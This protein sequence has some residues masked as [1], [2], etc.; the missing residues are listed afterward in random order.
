MGKRIRKL[1][2]NPI[3]ESTTEISDA[4]AEAHPSK[5]EGNPTEDQVGKIQSLQKQ[6]EDN[7]LVDKDQVLLNVNSIYN[8]HYAELVG[9]AV[10]ANLEVL[11]LNLTTNDVRKAAKRKE[12][13]ESGKADSKKGNVK[14]I[15][16]FIYGDQGVFD[17]IKNMHKILEKALESHSTVELRHK[18]TNAKGEE[19]QPLIND[20]NE[21]LDQRK[22][23]FGK[24]NSG[25]LKPLKQSTVDASRTLR[26]VAKIVGTDK[27]IIAPLQTND[28][29]LAYGWGKAKVYVPF[30]TYVNVKG[31]AKEEGE[32]EDITFSSSGAEDTT[33]IFRALKD[34]SVDVNEIFR[35]MTNDLVTPMAE[36]E[37][38]HRLSC[39][40]NGKLAWD[41]IFY[42]DGIV[43][44]VNTE[45]KDSQGRISM[46]LMDAN[47][48]GVEIR[49]KLPE[50]IPITWGEGSKVRVNG[51]SEYG[52]RKEGD[53]WLKGDIQLSAYG[54]YVYPEEATPAEV[55]TEQPVDEET[56]TDAWVQ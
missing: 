15:I 39:D 5:L 41:S 27:W 53:Q 51:K 21:L 30:T 19:K 16:G 4:I 24:N 26:V 7:Q 46:G 14:A 1:I 37:E 43:T 56:E 36:L 6:I 2:E 25:Y 54:V 34:D 50:W 3:E 42:I 49:V 38:Q 10:K 48:N 13:L 33:T 8:T 18:W 11:S 29:S 9:K 17:K 12:Y 23:L 40:A 22:K 31:E 20:Q 45:R 47:D 32:A 52:I 55:A 28:R 35:Q 44:Y